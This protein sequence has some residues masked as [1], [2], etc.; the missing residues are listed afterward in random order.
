[1]RLSELAKKVTATIYVPS[2]CSDPDPNIRDIA[3]LASAT[4]GE[5]SFLTNERFQTQL[6]STG[7]SAV[8][9]AKI[10]ESLSIP[11]LIHP[12]SYAT[13]AKVSQ[14][15]ARRAYPPEQGKPGSIA[16]NAVIGENVLIGV[17]VVIG[18]GATIESGVQL[19]AG[20]YV[21]PY[22]KI[23][24]NS[25]LYPK[26]V[27]M[28]ECWI[29]QRCVIHANAVIGA[30]GFGF[31]PTKEGIEKIPQR[32]RVILGD[33]VEVGS[34]SSIDR[35]AFEDTLIGR[36]TKIDSHVHVGHGVEIGE[37]GML[38]GLTGIAGSAKIGKRFISAG[39]A[40]VGPGII[41]G[42]GVILGAKAGAIRAIDE[43]GEYMG[44]PA[45]PKKKYWR[46]QSAHKLIQSLSTRLKDL[47]SKLSAMEK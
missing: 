6:I 14:C 10:Q 45:I 35:G 26:C 15:F 43:A 29:G 25:I 19:H 38:C 28:H 11:Q 37:F 39:Q 47:E 27:I 42:D 13:M 41:L 9:L 30:D 17:N 18:E 20:V 24:A 44:M 36:G 32:A 46:E 33:D 22:A 12:N 5:I 31:A 1:M 23:G 7:A 4:A 8:I 2:S 40:G 21:G 16:A 3:T 34:L